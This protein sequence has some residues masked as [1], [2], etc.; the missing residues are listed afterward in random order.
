MERA[1]TEAPRRDSGQ[2]TASA[3]APVP[4]AEAMELAS[5]PDAVAAAPGAAV[6]QVPR[7]VPVLEA[8]AP[9]KEVARVGASVAAPAARSV[10]APEA[11]LAVVP[12]V[13]VAPVWAEAVLAEA[14][15]Q[16]PVHR[17]PRRHVH[18]RHRE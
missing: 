13:A 10:W 1:R 17:H 5:E 8:V 18:H 14:Q 11:V 4:G 16:P 3:L 7:R 9:V 2:E 6:P 12:A 15:S